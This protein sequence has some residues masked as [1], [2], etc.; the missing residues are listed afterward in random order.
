MPTDFRATMVAV[1][2]GT[3]TARAAAAGAFSVLLL[4]AIK[5]GAFFR[6]NGEYKPFK[7]SSPDPDAIYVHAGFI[8][9]ACAWSAARF[10]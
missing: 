4:M 10:L 7:L 2:L 1:G 9:L 8:P 3:P 6:E 5:P